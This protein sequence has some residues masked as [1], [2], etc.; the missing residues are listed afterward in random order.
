MALDSSASTVKGSRK[1]TIT[2]ANATAA[3]RADV[4][5]RVSVVVVPA[6]RM[7]AIWLATLNSS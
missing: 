2:I 7:S 1:R 4:T 6:S 3:G 5:R